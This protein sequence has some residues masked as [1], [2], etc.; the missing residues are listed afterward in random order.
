[1]AFW[2]VIFINMANADEN[3]KQ[4][5]TN[6]DQALA[7]SRSDTVNINKIEAA[8]SA[9]KILRDAK[10]ADV[11]WE[12]EQDR[13]RFDLIDFRLA[14]ILAKA[15][16][17]EKAR[18]ALKAEIFTKTRDNGIFLHNTRDPDQF[19]MDVFQLHS[20]IMANTGYVSMPG[21]G[22]EVFELTNPDSNPSYA[23]SFQPLGKDEAGVNVENIGNDEE[24]HIIQVTKSKP[25]GGYEFASRAQL[26]SRKGEFAIT[27]IQQNDEAAFQ[28]G[29]IVKYVEYIGEGI[30][31]VRNSPV[32][33]L[34]LR[35][36]GS[37]IEQPKDAIHSLQLKID[38]PKRDTKNSIDSENHSSNPNSPQ[39]VTTEQ[40][41]N[42]LSKQGESRSTAWIYSLTG[43][44]VLFGLVFFMRLLK[45]K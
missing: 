37:E 7:E 34:I 5:T 35:I 14:L 41:G 3:Y 6:W 1:M 11:P 21:S 16:E 8:A 12:N 25:N 30:P 45:A 38:P 22:Y 29:G 24:R 43:L 32:S 31:L 13:A 42:A 17:H 40:S 4:I 20:E 2:V 18:D 33:D 19:A 23:F 28:I 44:V 15:G 36:K 9:M 39:T 26:I 27:L 10:S